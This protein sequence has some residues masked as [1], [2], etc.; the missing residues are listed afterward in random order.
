MLKKIYDWMIALTKSRHAVLAMAVV[1]FAESSFFPL[2]PDLMLVPMGIT[3]RSKVW[4]YAFICT[5][6]SVLGGILGYAIGALLYDSVGLW[7]VN[8]YGMAGKMETFRVWY[9]AN[10]QWAILFK[11]LTPIPFKIVTITSGLAG[12][13]FGWFVALAIV[14]RGARFFVLATLIHFYGEPIRDFIE[15]RLGLTLAIIAAI[16]VGGFVAVKYLF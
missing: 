16:I 8:L 1:S 9:Q 11:G 2:P 10:G 3:N 13:S 5:V 15:R 12:Y 7:L 14:T 6:A 4:Y